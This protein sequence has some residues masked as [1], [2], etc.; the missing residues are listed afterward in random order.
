MLETAA[1]FV[2]GEQPL[3][4][5]RLAATTELSLT[6]FPL[7]EI[8]PYGVCRVCFHG[9]PM[10]KRISGIVSLVLVFLT[11]G[12]PSKRNIWLRQMFSKH[13]ELP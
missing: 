9:R 2:A 3:A 6:V 4:K 7:A 13:E 11:S 1:D 5:L 12:A 10:N 8:D